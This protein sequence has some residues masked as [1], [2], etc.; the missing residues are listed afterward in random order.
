MTLGCI[1]TEEDEVGGDVGG[2]ERWISLR[3]AFFRSLLEKLIDRVP[4]VLT[5]RT[6]WMLCENWVLV[7]NS[8]MRC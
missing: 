8:R 1:R 4:M 2:L 3:A 7:S 6:E 5:Q